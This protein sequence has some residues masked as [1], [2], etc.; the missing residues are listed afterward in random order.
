MPTDAPAN[1]TL[2]LRG[3]LRDL[4]R[5]RVS[6]HRLTAM[7]GRE[8]AGAMLLL[9][10]LLALV[11]TPG[12]PLGTVVGL[13][14]AAIGLRLLAGCAELPDLIGRREVAHRH[15]VALIARAVPWVERVE[16]LLR[17]RLAALVAPGAQRLWALVVV[18]Q[19]V[20]IALPIP[21]GNPLPGAA[22]ALLG[23]GLTARD[24]AAVLASLV[25]STL[26]TGWGVGL[27]LAGIQV[28]GLAA[29]T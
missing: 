26:A 1:L 11:P 25:C 15:V 21:F 13:A 27:V 18:L 10:G 12:I 2:R 3:M 7:L 22:V 6:L 16:S 5:E 29:G 8:A 14:I 23:L 28:Y 4:P 19:G 24:G 17:P 9:F 20:L